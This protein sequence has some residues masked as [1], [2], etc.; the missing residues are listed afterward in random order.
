MRKTYVTRLPDKAGAFLQAS[1]IISEEN[2]N[3]V[4]VSYNRALDVHTLF[5][6]VNADEQ[7]QARITDRLRENGY[8]S[9]G[10]T[11]TQIL[12]TVLK[13]RDEPGAVTPVLEVL[14]KYKVNISYISYQADSSKVQDFK[15]GL[16]IDR[17]DEVS[18]MITEISRIC[19]MQILDYEVTDRLLDGTVFYITFANEM[20]TI[21]GLSQEKTNTVLICA[22]RMMQMLDEQNKPVLQ[23]FDYIRRFASFVTLHKGDGFDPVVTVHDAAPGLKLYQI[24]PPCGSNTYI[25]EYE[26]RLLFVDSGF[27]CYRD[28]MVALLR[29]MIPDFDNKEKTAFITHA[30]VDHAGLLSLFDHVSMSGE[31]AENFALQRAGAQDFREQTPAFEPYIILSKIISGYTPPAENLCDVFGRRSGDEL[32]EYIGSRS[33][34]EWTFDFYEG[35]GGHVRGETVIVCEELQII[36]SGDIFVNIRGFSDAQREFNSLAPFLMT[37]VDTDPAL[38]RVSREALTEKYKG[39]YL[40]CPGHGASMKGF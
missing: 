3:I 10:N 16:L 33:F 25:F 32:F 29:R 23:T 35:K 36:F 24:D 27:A 20:R 22:N 34:A 11:G 38:S 26:N 39:D 17:P 30:D 12:M 7:A 9:D 5:M 1:R 2:G 21:L 40:V 37:G 14:D 13:L 19:E 18:S 15:M 4:R 6:E 28:E 31:C 8:L